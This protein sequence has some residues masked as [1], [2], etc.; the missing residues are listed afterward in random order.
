MTNDKLEELYIQYHRFV[1]TTAYK[2]LGDY[3]LAEDVSHDV[4]LRLSDRWVCANI[5][6]DKRKRYLRTVTLH[7]AIDYYHLRKQY[8]ETIQKNTE[9]LSVHLVIEEEDA[10]PFIRDE[11][12]CHM[13]Y[14]LRMKN[15]NW[16][17]AILQ[18]K[19]YH[20]PMEHIAAELGV[21]VYTVKS[22][23]KNGRKWL[24]KKYG[25]SI[26]TK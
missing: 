12:A 10:I 14:T 18:N 11:F 1:K 19:V 21:S 17:M 15:E 5:E 26:Y 13:L 23:I 6:P 4:F 3:D 7:K 8:Y 22:W 9:L 24:I 2:M 16:Y 25:E 20:V